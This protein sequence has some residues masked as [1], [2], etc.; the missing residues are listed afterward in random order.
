MRTQSAGKRLTGEITVGKLH[1]GGEVLAQRGLTLWIT[2][3]S[4]VLE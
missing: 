2:E 1:P 3:E 4:Q